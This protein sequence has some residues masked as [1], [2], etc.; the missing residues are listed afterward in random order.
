VVT[1]RDLLRNLVIRDLKV[2]YRGSFIGFLWSL[3]NPLLMMLVYWFVFTQL[4]KS[5]KAQFHIFVF[6]ALLPWNWCAAA[7]M[8]GITSIVGN[9][10]LIKKVYFPREL[11]PLSV[12]ISNGINFLFALPVLLFLI[13]LAGN[14]ADLRTIKGH[15]KPVAAVAAQPGGAFLASSGDD[16][17]VRLWQ[18]ADGAPVRKWDLGVPAEG[19]AF[20]P[21]GST[22]AAV[23][24]DR[25]VRLWRV[26]DG[27][28]LP[29]LPLPRGGSP[30]GPTSVAFGP[31]GR[32]LAVG[33][34]DGRVHVWRAS[35]D[36]WTAAPAF[37][38]TP[39]PAIWQVA[40][41]PDGQYL[42][43]AG[44]DHRVR[45]WRVTAGTLAQTLEGLP[46]PA[47]SLGVS[48][49]GTLIAA[50]ASDGTV[51][52][53]RTNDGR[54]QRRLASTPSPVQSLAFAPGP[55]GLLVT[56]GE[57]GVVRLWRAFDGT[58][59]REFKGHSARVNSVAFAPDAASIVSGSSDNTV[60]QWV[61]AGE[62]HMTI[63]PNIIWLPVL[64]IAEGIFLAGVAFFLAALNV[65][66]RD[67]QAIMEVG[68]T[69]W[70]F[71]T[72][73][74]YD[75][76]EVLPDLANWMYWLNPMASLISNYRIILYT[77]G[78]DPTSTGPDATFILRTLLTAGVVLVAGYAFFRSL[79]RRFGEE[80]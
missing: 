22:L 39:G 51:Q 46:A 58:L 73:I 30:T 48:P 77:N 65:F 3:L 53:W 41:T 72:P 59:V 42:V 1:Y 11:L 45:L 23:S 79:S 75:A 70:F 5:N 10:H 12:V 15:T 16:G 55:S 9:A 66:F 2:R 44:D 25:Q 32:T 35:G 6:V 27:A 36:G 67:T 29:V 33:D 47:I 64:I 19:V 49:D 21:D 54:L 28:P 7:V 4:L 24:G 57:D 74:I 63:S 37:G 14:G 38:Q 56:G 13:L 60:R 69:A 50:G 76:R 26:N 71:L 61:T 31:D 52:I 8:G 34:Q 40:F 78:L 20:A 62:T 68:I 17:T 43:T 18:A 80:L